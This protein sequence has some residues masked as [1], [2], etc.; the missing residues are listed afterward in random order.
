MS[1][2]VMSSESGKCDMEAEKKILKCDDGA[3]NGDLGRR[4][5]VEVLFLSDSM[6]CPACGWNLPRVSNPKVHPDNNFLQLRLS[7]R[8]S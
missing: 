5:R 1:S 3:V 7:W 4:W 2:V 6:R 8:E